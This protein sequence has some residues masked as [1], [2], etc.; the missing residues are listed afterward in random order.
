PPLQRADRGGDTD[1]RAL[2]G[3]EFDGCKAQ[4]YPGGE[5]VTGADGPAVDLHDVSA[6]T[7]SGVGDV[8]GHR[9]VVPLSTFDLRVVE[10]EARIREAVSEG[11][12]GGVTVAVEEA[13]PVPP[14]VSDLGG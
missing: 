1:V 11:E 7:G 5:I 10:R 2:A 14:V 4:Q 8:D 6:G 3:S 13:L 12:R 9:E